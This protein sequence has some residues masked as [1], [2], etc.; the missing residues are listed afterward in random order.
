MGVLG[1][2][3]GAAALHAAVHFQLSRLG[4][5][6]GRPGRPARAARPV[7]L[8]TVAAGVALMVWAFAAHS[9]AAPQGWELESGLTPGYLLRTGRYRLSRNP[10][11]VGEAAAW[12][13][14]RLVYASPA[15]WAGLASLCAAFAVI[16]RWEEQ[17]L[18]DR[19]GED[20]RAYLAEVPRWLPGTS[21]HC[22]ARVLPPPGPLPAVRPS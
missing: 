11:Y 19:F 4:G 20:Y 9:A 10:M 7:G 1:W 18:L 5:R 16:V 2:A 6:A 17:Q 12:A 3:L 22:R 15:V 14:W 8:V 21:R 13:G